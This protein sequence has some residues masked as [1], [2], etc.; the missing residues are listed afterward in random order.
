MVDFKKGDC[1]ELKSGG[2]VMTVA[3]F[4]PGGSASVVCIWFTGNSPQT[5][6]YPPECLKPL[7]A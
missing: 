2:P 1:V 6:T 5:Y 4:L 7:V 3:D